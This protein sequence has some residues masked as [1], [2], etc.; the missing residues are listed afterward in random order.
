MN[1]ISMSKFRSG[2]VVLF[3]GLLLSPCITLSACG[4]KGPLY[5]PEEANSP[6]PAAKPAASPPAAGAED[7]AHQK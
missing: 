6:V 3:A 7:G 4:K 2:F 5:L 1:R